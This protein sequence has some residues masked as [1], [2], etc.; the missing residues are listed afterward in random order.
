MRTETKPRLKEMGA[1]FVVNGASMGSCMTATYYPTTL[2]TPANA[3]TYPDVW[4]GF[5]LR[6]TIAK[7]Q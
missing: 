6:A 3:A 7:V 1:P 2:V 5:L 4:L